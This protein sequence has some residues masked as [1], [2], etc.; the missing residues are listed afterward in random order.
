MIWYI[1]FDSAGRLIHT[2]AESVRFSGV[3]ISD[4]RRAIKENLPCDDFVD[5]TVFRSKERKLLAS[6]S[7]DEFSEFIQWFDL[8]DKERREKLAS[9]RRVANLSLE[10]DEVL[11]IQISSASRV[12]SFLSSPCSLHCAQAFHF[13]NRVGTLSS[14][15]QPI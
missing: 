12:D 9:A 4:L 7:E 15:A 6:G 5:L 14:F 2:Q 11:F 1:C 8:S 3:Y 10:E 13:H